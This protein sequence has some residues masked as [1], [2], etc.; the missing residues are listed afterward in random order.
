MVG[1]MGVFSGA[2][3]YAEMRSAWILPGKEVVRADAAKGTL[4]LTI[5]FV[6]LV[7]FTHNDRMKTISITR[8]GR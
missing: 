6:H 2:F 1:G 4:I 8:V 5:A 7:F 3:F